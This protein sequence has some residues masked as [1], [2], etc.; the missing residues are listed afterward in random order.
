MTVLLFVLYKTSFRLEP[1]E[2]SPSFKCSLNMEAVGFAF[3]VSGLGTLVQQAFSIYRHIDETRYFGE[4]VYQQ[5][6]MFQHQ[7]YRFQNWYSELQAIDH[8]QARGIVVQSQITSSPPIPLL[9]TSLAIIPPDP[10]QW[11]RNVISQ[12]KSILEAVSELCDKYH[13]E[14]ASTPETKP[15]KIKNTTLRQGLLPS[16]I[17]AAVSSDGK[18]AFAA[19]E[20]II[21]EGIIQDKM[22]FLAKL[23]YGAILWK[24]A[25][26]DKFEG[27]ISQFKC[28][29]EALDSTLPRPTK[30]LIDLLSSVQLLSG[31]INGSNLRLIG[32]ATSNAYEDLSR[33]AALKSRSQSENQ[34]APASIVIST[35]AIHG[36]P[37]G[38]P[39]LRMLAS[40][41]RETEN[42]RRPIL[43]E[44]KNTKNITS[45]EQWAEAKLNVEALV[46]LLGSSK[47]PRSLST[48]QCIGYFESKRKET[49]YGL[50]MDIPQTADPLKAP[51]S[52]FELMEEKKI[53]PTLAQRIKIAQ[54]LVISL[55]ELQNAHWLH[56]D[57]SSKSILFFFGTSSNSPD[58]DNPYL[59]GFDFARASAN[60]DI[61]VER[62]P[63]DFNY[64]WH[65]SLRARAQDK[66]KPRPQYHAGF[67]V[68]S[69]GL[70]LLDIVLWCSISKFH[71]N[72]HK[73]PKTFTET[74]IALTQREAAHRFG[75]PYREAVLKCIT[76]NGLQ[77][78]QETMPT[79]T[80]FMVSPS[81]QDSLKNGFFCDP[82]RF[83]WEVVREL[84]RCHCGHAT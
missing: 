28:W 7:A 55:L 73:D 20:K 64:Y 50:V 29:N 9:S 75:E 14:E 43:I 67:D 56:K 36:M 24:E 31:E 16:T 19:Q 74:L 11:L 83:Y 52:L 13:I 62:E 27:L 70:V 22:G 2:Y 51:K 4:N 82:E 25:D 17:G 15:R 71:S 42:E 46:Q 66:D 68:Y 10:N 69:V 59:A 53:L 49:R 18:M 34:P 35:D 21:R 54:R 8:A 63:G 58:F 47:K 1:P 72:A 30:V 12:I 45:D 38:V 41:E 33:R 26:K 3:G 79:T 78:E 40:L 23:K 6:V 32:D 37:V 48:L 81:F 80:E 77:E 44:L 84:E 76:G 65:P 57:F 60:I 39:K 61:S 5:Y